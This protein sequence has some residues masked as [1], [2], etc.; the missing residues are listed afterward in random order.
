MHDRSGSGLGQHIGA[1]PGS[2][3]HQCAG[4]GRFGQTLVATV[5]LKFAAVEP[6]EAQY[7]SV[8]QRIEMRIARRSRKT[9]QAIQVGQAQIR[10]TPDPLESETA[11]LIA[12]REAAQSARGR[13]D[14]IQRAIGR[15]MQIA[16]T[17]NYVELGHDGADAVSDPFDEFQRSGTQ[18]SLEHRNR[19]RHRAGDKHPALV[20]GQSHGTRTA[21]SGDAVAT[22]R[23]RCG[24]ATD[25]VQRLAQ[26][27]SREH[28]QAIACGGSD[29]D[30]QAVTADRD[31]GGTGHA[32]DR[33]T[34]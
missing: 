30:R 13:A 8:G 26:A 31:I 33:A 5:E 23:Y 15:R 20:I 19:V 11:S 32:L 10:S 17:A 12:D 25:V 21:Q 1:R 2:V 28:H 4:S 29:V 18:I 14:R 7:A 27:F 22:D 9:A 34:G 24:V 3:D 6:A 16:D